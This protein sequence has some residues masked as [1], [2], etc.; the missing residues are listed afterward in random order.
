MKLF[1]GFAY[2]TSPKAKS[3]FVH[4]GFPD[5]FRV[6]LGISK[7]LGALALILPRTPDKI[8]EFAY[9]GFAITFV[10][11]FVAHLSSGDQL[12]DAIN[13]VVAL[14]VLSISYIYYLRIN[15]ATG[16]V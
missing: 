16:T 10:S 2:L 13:P 12:K 6:E 11:A 7:F 8:R 3:K 15:E 4:L 14:V 9:A 1:A 5:Y